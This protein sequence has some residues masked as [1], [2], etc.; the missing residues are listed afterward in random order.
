MVAL[1][2]SRAPG[3]CWPTPKHWRARP[4]CCSRRPRI[5]RSCAEHVDNQN[6]PNRPRAHAAPVHRPAVTAGSQARSIGPPGRIGGGVVTWLPGSFLGPDA[7]SA[8]AMKSVLPRCSVTQTTRCPTLRSTATN[9]S[10]LCERTQSPAL[11]AF[12]T[13]WAVPHVFVQRVDGSSRRCRSPVRCVETAWRKASAGHV[14]DLHSS[15][16]APRHHISRHQ[17]L[18]SLFSVRRTVSRRTVLWRDSWRAL[19]SSSSSF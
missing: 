17:G 7:P 2:P 9:R 10:F 13:S 1:R 16:S 15:I 8:F 11:L 5:N 12:S 18:R 14:R 6:P 3:C 4:V 19:R